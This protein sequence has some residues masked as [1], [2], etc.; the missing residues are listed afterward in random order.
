MKIA[1][2]L[3]IVGLVHGVMFRASLCNYAR[4]LGVSGWVRN[5]V[6]GSVE[7][8]VEGEEEEVKKV[9]EWT[10]R[11]PPMARVDAVHTQSSTVRNVKGFV[12]V[13]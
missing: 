13:G 2:R 8:W 3:V 11:G 10:R 7:A 6:D 5:R 9:I 4:S 1:V 12:V